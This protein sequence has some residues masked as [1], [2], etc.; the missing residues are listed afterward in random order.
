M[1]NTQK[2]AFA[3]FFNTIATNAEIRIRSAECQ[4]LPFERAMMWQ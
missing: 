2:M 1:S 3:D 4:K